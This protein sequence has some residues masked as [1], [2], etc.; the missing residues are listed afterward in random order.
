MRAPVV[1]EANQGGLDLVQAG[2]WAIGHAFRCGE[3][4]EVFVPGPALEDLALAVQRQQGM[5]QNIIWLSKHS[6]RMDQRSF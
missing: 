1:A 5:V 2:G 6:G 4:D 3:L